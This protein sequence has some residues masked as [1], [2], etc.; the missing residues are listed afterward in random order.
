[1]IT[2][3]LRRFVAMDALPMIPNAS[4]STPL[5]FAQDDGL[6]LPVGMTGLWLRELR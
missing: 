5:R 6:N 3:E 2:R 4:P 1:M